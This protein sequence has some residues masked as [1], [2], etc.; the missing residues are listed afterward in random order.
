VFRAAVNISEELLGQSDDDAGGASQV[1][2]LVFV[3]IR[4]I[5]RV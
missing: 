2:E 4:D 1:T 3:L 5:G